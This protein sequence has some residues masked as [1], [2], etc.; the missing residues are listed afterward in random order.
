MAHAA[1]FVL[2]AG[3]AATAGILLRSLDASVTRAEVD[4]D[5]NAIQ[6]P[7]DGRSQKTIRI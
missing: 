4:H 7:S 2:M 5:A 1:F 3:V 6:A